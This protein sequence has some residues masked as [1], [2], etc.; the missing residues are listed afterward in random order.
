[1]IPSNQKVKSSALARWSTG[2][3]ATFLAA[4]YLYFARDGLRGHWAADDMMNLYG[5]WHPGPLRLLAS[6][7]T[8]WR[9]DYR[10][11][12]G[13]FY[14]PLYEAFGLNPFPCRVAIL[15]LLGLNV[16]L[17]WRFARILGAGQLTAALA[18]IVLSYH[19]RLGQ[20]YY[21]VDFIYDILCFTFYFAAFNY[22]ASIRSRG[23]RLRPLEILTF[24]ALFLAALDSKEMA[25]TMPFAILA[26]EALYHA[27]S[28]WRPKEA[29]R[30]LL[31]PASMILIAGVVN[32]VDI[33]GKKFGPEGLMKMP[34]YQPL[35]TWDNFL[36]FQRRAMEDIAFSPTGRVWVVWLAAWTLATWLAWRR[37][38]PALRFCWFF[39]LFAPLPI[40]FL[41]RTGPSLYVVMA[42]WAVLAGAAVADLAGCISTAAGRLP[43]TAGRMGSRAALALVLLCAL[44]PWFRLNLGEQRHVAHSNMLAE[45]PLTQDVIQQVQRA[46]LRLKPNAKIAF[47]T[48]PFTD[49]DMAFIVPLVLH[50]RTLDVHLQRKTPWSDEEIAKMDHVFTFEKGKMVQLR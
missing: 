38:R 45:S 37:N 12:G 18:C 41:N 29:L 19:A 5:V 4:Y 30:W 10:P 34:A 25:I 40:E 42:G 23:R 44:V 24:L 2:A 27:P 9:G 11:M 17:L 20:L 7:F 49:W 36:L 31:G 1:L 22:Y 13:A 50:D 35:V 14:V 16:W 15:F 39:I 32:L 8:I 47:L 21:A 33:L 43:G 48:D 46:K 6:L 3:I 26:Y 28:R